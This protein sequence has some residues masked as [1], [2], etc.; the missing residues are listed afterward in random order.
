MYSFHATKLFHTIE[1]G[2]LIYNNDEYKKMFDLY[3]NFGITG[4]EDVDMIGINAKMN[5]FQAAMGL[6]VLK[7]MNEI[8]EKRRI[9][10]ERYSNNLAGING[11][12]MVQNKEDV[13]VNY[14]YLP[15]LVDETSYGHT[16]D[17]L[18]LQ[19]EKNFINARKYF[20]PI[21]TN[22]RCYKDKYVN[23]DVSVAEFVSQR[24]ITLPIYPDLSLDDVDRICDVINEF[25]RI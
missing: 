4:P 17:E 2:A 3:K 5:E 21:T 18:F 7:H 14:A 22:F 13:K 10:T 25:K 20:Y 15:I 24:I 6:A 8:I 9:I 1:G 12:V 19:L 16:R 11:I 23:C